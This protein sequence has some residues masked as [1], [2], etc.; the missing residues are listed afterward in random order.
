MDKIESQTGARFKKSQLG[1][2][3]SGVLIC[4]YEVICYAKF[5]VEPT[6]RTLFQHVFSRLQ[7][8]TGLKLGSSGP[9]PGMTY[10]VFDHKN[11][12]RRNWA[13]KN[14]DFV[15]DSSIDDNVFDWAVGPGLA[16]AIDYIA[17]KDP[18]QYDPESFLE[19]EQFWAGFEKILI[20]LQDNLLLDRLRNLR[21]NAGATVYDLLFTHIPHCESEG[22][23]V[24]AIRVLTRLLKKYPKAIWD[25]IGDAK[26]NVIADAIIS[27]QIFTHLLQQSLDPC[28]DRVDPSDSAPFATSW[29]LPW[30]D[31]LARDRKYDAC[32]TLLQTLFHRFGNDKALGEP[33]RSACVRTGLD[34]LTHTVQSFT[35]NNTAV[36]VGGTTHLYANMT[37]DLVTRNQTVILD[38]INPRAG[39]PS[40]GWTTFKVSDSVFKLIRATMALDQKLYYEENQSVRAQNPPPG[41]QFRK[42]NAFWLMVKE[43]YDS[44]KDQ[45]PIT[46][47]ILS[48]LQPLIGVEQS[49]A[50]KSGE[51]LGSCVVTFNAM[52]KETTDTIAMVLGRVEDLE[53]MELNSVFADRRPIKVIIGLSVHDEKDLADA[54]LQVLKA[55][56]SE[57]DKMEA[58]QQL[59]RLHPEQTLASIVSTLT[60]ISQGTMPW[61]PIRP[62]VNMIRAVLVGLVDPAAGVLRSENLSPK[63]VAILIRWWSDL[64]RFVSRCC[65]QIERWSHYISNNIMTEFCREIMELAEA[66]IAEDGLFASAVA[67]KRDEKESMKKLLEPAKEN[68]KGMENMIRLKDLWLVDVTV[69]V[70]CKI[71]T[72]LRQNGLEINEH[73]K[74]L[75]IDASAPTASGRYIR[76]TNLN[77]QQ[78]A[79]L[80][81]ALGHKL[82]DVRAAQVE[83]ISIKDATKKQSRLDSWSKS[84]ASSSASS[85]GSSLS[86]KD[87]R[88]N[89]DDVLALSKNLENPLLK[90]LEAKR[91]KAKAQILPKAPDQKSISALK[92]SRQR[93]K[94]EKAKR[95]A[96]AIAKAKQLRGEG[97]DS[98]TGKD[99]SEI[100]VNSSDE[101][102]EG[103]SDDGDSSYQ[104]AALSTGGQK[105]LDEAEKRRLQA[106]RD[107]T[108]RPVK[109]QRVQRSAK[110]MRARLIP[111]MDKLH[112]AILAWDIFHNGNDPPNGPKATEVATKYRDPM[113]YR[114]TFF[115]LL[116]SEAWRAFVTAKDEVTS[117]S[118]GM[119]I[120]SRASVDSYL[121]VTFTLEITQHRE[122]GAS[123]GDI[124][125]VSEA[126]R[127]LD[128]Q[129]ARHCLARVQKIKYKKELVEVMYRVASRNNPLVACLSPGSTVYGVKITNM[130]TI[131]REYAALESLQFYDLMDEILK[132]EPSPILRY[133]EEKV[134]NY[135]NNWALNNG[136]ALAV[137]GAQEN[138]GFT[139]IQG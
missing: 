21:G 51:T 110:E 3:Q 83:V 65:S 79:E 33:A 120:A 2:H 78:R 68:F 128:D 64:W 27:N 137:L 100:M 131:E 76:T 96:E 127:P 25:F 39:E 136:Q 29:V 102:S 12:D 70:L 47:D 125:L 37:I 133:G 36:S 35:D 49:R 107:M 73:S 94:L 116:A 108:R 113:S 121:E 101:E 58:F 72:R 119:K 30:M 124:L 77:D 50:K 14:W 132:A 71:L 56:T 86:A 109:K 138:D 8:K 4:I 46:Q 103:E 52:L 57:D 5:F 134:S 41:V 53:V 67:M 32:E 135:M 118:F 45:V 126:E 80:L 117:Q 9:L 24:V 92:E 15:E 1:E 54:S 19:M 66:I 106:L 75:I 122:R 69:R 34:A 23:L 62:M 84:G 31:S 98:L 61:G 6:R 42:S 123:E 38:N 63:L 16:S 93:A 97:A 139:L 7:G 74:K 130:T 48:S 91:A 82:E 28:W 18:Q 105:S 40:E 112:N 55:W 85:P 87:Q 104:L 129:R 10:F 89:R 43:V 114:D 22:L 20:K 111:P 44:T 95:D 99:K 13:L 26:P 11:E 81:E 88:S 17:T 59:A 115:P 60:Q 90:Q